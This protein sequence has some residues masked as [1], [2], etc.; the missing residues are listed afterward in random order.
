[1]FKSD[2]NEIWFN[3]DLDTGLGTYKAKLKLY[4]DEIKKKTASGDEVKLDFETLDI[5]FEVSNSCIPEIEPKE[6]EGC[7]TCTLHKTVA[8]GPPTQKGRLNDLPMRNKISDLFEFTFPT[9]TPDNNFFL[10]PGS[11]GT[12]YGLKLKSIDASDPTIAD[13]TPNTSM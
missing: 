1:M 4:Y 6:V 12:A 10:C 8:A 3:P 11:G 13:P 7:M 2:L 9:Y 5:V